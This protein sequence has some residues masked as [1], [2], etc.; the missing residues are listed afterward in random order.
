MA[1]PR[2]CIPC[3]TCGQHMLVTEGSKLHKVEG[4]ET[5]EARR[6]LRAALELGTRKLRCNRC[7]PSATRD[8]G[9]K[10]WLVLGPFRPIEYRINERK[11]R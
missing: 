10:K 6:R 5:D 7:A 3:D 11:P 8:D 2:M 1:E 4:A 9:T